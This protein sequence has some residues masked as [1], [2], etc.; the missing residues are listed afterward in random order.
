MAATIRPLRS[1]R[2]TAQR[3]KPMT[4]SQ[5]WGKVTTMAPTPEGEITTTEILVPEV[6]PVEEVE[7]EHLPDKESTNED[8]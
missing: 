2:R 5:R 7:E 3:G 6:V 8:N 1:R 4:Q